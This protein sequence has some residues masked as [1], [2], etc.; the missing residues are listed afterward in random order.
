MIKELSPTQQAAIELT[1]RFV[2]SELSDEPTGHD[3]WHA[4]RVRNVATLI[5]RSESADLFVVA[6]A[7]LLHDVGDFKFTGSDD[8]GPRRAQQFL[9]GIQIAPVVVDAVQEIIRHLSFK[10]S[11]V[12]DVPMSLEGR[13]VQDAD[14]LDAIGAVGVARTF[15]YGGF[16]HRP[17]HDPEVPPAERQTAAEYRNSVGTTINHFHEKLLLVQDR[18]RTETAMRIAK[19]RQN[20][21]LDFLAEFEEEWKGKDAVEVIDDNGIP[22]N[23]ILSFRGS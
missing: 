7:S 17:I 1:S 13:C 8:E 6:L 12:Q 22:A 15:A 5:A 16:V 23:A 20:Y 11:G 9:R 18:L 10:G 2:R 21:M 14:R 4:E 3:W 19:R